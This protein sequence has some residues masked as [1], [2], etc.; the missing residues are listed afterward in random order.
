MSLAPISVDPE[1]IIT[2]FQHLSFINHTA[3]SFVFDSSSRSH[4]TASSCHTG[5]TVQL[6]QSQCKSTPHLPHSPCRS[7]TQPSLSF[8]VDHPRNYKD[9]HSYIPY[10]ASY[11]SE[12]GCSA[13][14]KESCPESSLGRT[15]RPTSI[16]PPRLN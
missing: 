15:S 1:M 5:S 2:S 16:S 10:H 7:T 3:Q 9:N 8:T 12:S 11:L 6:A 4:F 14:T 13:T